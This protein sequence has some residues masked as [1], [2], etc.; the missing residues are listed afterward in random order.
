MNRGH[1]QQQFKPES[2][3]NTIKGTKNTKTSLLPK[4]NQSPLKTRIKIRYKAQKSN[5]IK[6]IKTKP[7]AS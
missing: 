2:Y 6:A 4:T 5:K 7:R 1:N 3:N